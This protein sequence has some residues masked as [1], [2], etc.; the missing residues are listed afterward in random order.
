MLGQLPATTLKAGDTTQSTNDS[1][2]LHYQVFE[3]NF[4]KYP[5]RVID[6]LQLFMP[7]LDCQQLID[8]LLA[9]QILIDGVSAEPNSLLE[10]AQQLTLVISSHYEQ[11]VDCNW[12]PIWQNDQI[13][14]AYKT[15]PLA[16]SRTTR[17]LHNTLISLVRRQTP[18]HSA[19]LLHRLDI[20]T[21]GL[22]LLSKDKASDSYWKPK[23]KTLIEKKVYHAIVHNSPEWSEFDCETLLAERIDSEIRCKMYVVDPTLPAHL[24]KKPKPS[25]TLFKKLK[26]QGDFSLIECRLMTGRKHQIRAHL[27]H[28]GLPIVGDKIYAHQGAFFIKRLASVE[29]LDDTDYRQLKAKNHLLRA[30]ELGLRLSLDTPL[31]NLQCPSFAEDITQELYLGQV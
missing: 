23:L 4:T 20:E 27:A 21:S 12:Y 30:V 31:V 28:L 15:A 14:A 6:Y 9:N 7:A 16:V 10:N 17:N 19:Q 5:M 25:R 11:A 26:T 8:Y 13:L 18:H 24:Y 29:G 22:I 3:E 2:A 1:F